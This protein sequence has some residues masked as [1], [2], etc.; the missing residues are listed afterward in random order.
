ML[1]DSKIKALHTPNFPTKVVGLYEN[2][3]SSDIVKALQLTIKKLLDDRTNTGWTTSGHTA[4]DV[5][6]SVMGSNRELFLGHHTHSDIGK[7]LIK[8][9]SS[10]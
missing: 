3:T 5:P 9:I 4:I 6:I 8:L 2:K 10:N 7:I 1:K